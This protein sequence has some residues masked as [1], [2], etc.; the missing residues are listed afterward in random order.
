MKKY[1][2]RLEFFEEGNWYLR[3]FHIKEEKN[4]NF[5]TRITKKCKKKYQGHAKLILVGTIDRE[6]LEEKVLDI[7]LFNNF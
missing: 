2:Y 6:T 1:V 7:E 4:L 5:L 3:I